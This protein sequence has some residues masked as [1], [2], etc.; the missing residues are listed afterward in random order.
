MLGVYMCVWEGCWMW[1][2][3]DGGGMCVHVCVYIYVCGVLVIV[4]GDG[5][6]GI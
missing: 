1:W 4:V 5:I 3:A 2:G 6:G